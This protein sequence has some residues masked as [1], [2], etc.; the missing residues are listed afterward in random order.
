LYMR[1]GAAHSV[2]YDWSEDLFDKVSNLVSLFASLPHR[3]LCHT[4]L[5]KEDRHPCDKENIAHCQICKGEKWSDFQTLTSSLRDTIEESGGYWLNP[6]AIR[7]RTISK[8]VGGV[9]PRNV[10]VLQASYQVSICV[11][12]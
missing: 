1:G 5:V 8:P 7:V 4:G 11:C 9:T 12:R 6:N 10:S 3:F 2:I